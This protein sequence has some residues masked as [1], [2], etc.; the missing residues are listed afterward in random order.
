M[1]LNEVDMVEHIQF[2]P[3]DPATYNSDLFGSNTSAIMLTCYGSNQPLSY[4]I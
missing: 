4:W 3:T 2:V 1:A